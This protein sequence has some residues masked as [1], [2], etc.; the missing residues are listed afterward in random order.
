MPR[1]RRQCLVCP[2]LTYN[3]RCEK[4]ESEYNRKREREKNTPERAA[5]K[6]YLYDANYRKQR[7]LVLAT[8]THCHICKLPFTD[9][10]R[11][12]TDHL[13]P[14]LG[15]ASPLAAAHARCNQSRGNRP[16]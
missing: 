4:H 16:L 12:Q 2:E 7:G 11:V 8:A 6:R 10:D 3:T 15:G 14:E 13:Y 1:F 5:K 9:T